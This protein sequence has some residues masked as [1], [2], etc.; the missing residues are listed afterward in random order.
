[1]LFIYGTRAGVTVRLLQAMNH[2]WQRLVWY[3]A[4]VCPLWWESTQ[5]RSFRTRETS[6]DTLRFGIGRGATFS[7]GGMRGEHCWGSA[8][9][10]FGATPWR[11]F[12]YRATPSVHAN[13]RE[14]GTSCDDPGS[15][16]CG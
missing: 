2:R 11:T 12:G 6:F 16:T 15:G 3:V 7:T 4:L 8:R 1:M 14:G 10:G 5:S 9:R 13:C